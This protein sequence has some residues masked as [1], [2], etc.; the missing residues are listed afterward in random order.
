MMN[1]VDYPLIIGVKARLSRYLWKLCAFLPDRH[2]LINYCGGKIYLN[3]R[4]SPMMM[5]RALGVY[6]YW[7]TRLLLDTVR[8]G[9]TIVDAGVN[10]GY[11]SLLFARLMGDRGRVLSFE[12]DPAN[13]LWFR[14]SIEANGYRCIKLYQCALSDGE[15]EATFYPGKKS[16]WGSLF[17]SPRK[18]A[19]DKRPITVRTRRLDDILREEGIDD[20]DL[21]KIDVEGAD[22]LVL[23]GAEDILRKSEKV[24]LVMDVDVRG[25]EAERVFDFLTSCGF[26]IYKIGPELKAIKGM[27]E[28]D[29]DIY[30]VKAYAP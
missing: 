13:C 3:L 29:K 15:G 17:F 27:K 18:A 23:R 12:P 21:I 7:K 16:G 24:K 25:E 2:F 4:E 9:M 5:D 11:F 6:E 26:R 20:I 1:P 19:P 28:V 8:E 30:A 14:R 22:L 10:K